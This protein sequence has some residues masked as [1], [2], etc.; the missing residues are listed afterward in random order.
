MQSLRMRGNSGT[1]QALTVALRVRPMNGN[2]INIGA[3]HISHVVDD[4]L[5]VLQDPNDDAD[6]ILRVNRSREKHYTFDCA[7]GPLSTQGDV[8]QSTTKGLIDGVLG[9]YN[10][11]VFAYGPTGA[12]KTYTML[13]TGREPGIMMLTLNDLYSEIE[14]NAEEITCRVSISYLE[15]YNEMIRDLLNPGIG[16]LEL[17]EDHRGVNVVGLKEVETISVEEIMR[18]LSLGNSHR[19]CEPTAINKTSSRSHAVLQV[20]V[21]VRARVMDV[22]QEVKTGKLFMVDLAGSERAAQTKNKGKRMLEGA[23]INR[24][25]LALGNCI[26]ALGGP[27]KVQYVNYRDSKL[28]RLLKDSLGGNCRT[29]MIAHVSPAS[30]SFDESRNTLKYAERAKHI[31]TKI[32]VKVHDVSYHILQYNNIIADLR[33]EIER[34]KRQLS[35]EKAHIGSSSSQ[36]A[37]EFDAMLAELKRV[38]LEQGDRRQELV[39]VECALTLNDLEIQKAKL[40]EEYL[41][42]VGEDETEDIL[43]SLPHDLVGEELTASEEYERRAVLSHPSINNGE[44]EEDIGIAGLRGERRKLSLQQ[45][46]LMH[47]LGHMNARSTDLSERLQEVLSTSLQKEVVDMLLKTNSLEMHFAEQSQVAACIGLH[48]SDCE[49]LI[50][51]LLEQNSACIA[52]IKGQ[53]EF[54][55]KNDIEYPPEFEVAYQKLL[56]QH[57]Y[58]SNWHSW[59]TRL[60]SIP[61][62]AHLT[63]GTDDG[64]DEASLG[65]SPSHQGGPHSERLGLDLSSSQNLTISS[66]ASLPS[67][68]KVE[69]VESTTSDPEN[70]RPLSDNATKPLQDK[71][72]IIKTSPKRLAKSFLP[73]LTSPKLSDEEEDHLSLLP[74]STKTKIKSKTSRATFPKLP[75][76]KSP[77]LISVSRCSTMS[78]NRTAKK[79]KMALLDSSHSLSVVS[80]SSLG[81]EAWETTSK[82]NKTKSSHSQKS[83]LSHTAKKRSKKAPKHVV[84]S[85]VLSS[86]PDLQAELRQTPTVN[87]DAILE[88]R[89]KASQKK[90]QLT[91][92]ST[93]ARD[94][95]GVSIKKSQKTIKRA[96]K[97][98]MAFSSPYATKPPP[99]NTQG[100]ERTRQSLKIS[101]VGFK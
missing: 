62:E 82:K 52:T 47:K 40:K 54:I 5:V 77:P 38:L 9:G 90:R 58:L 96:P 19:T 37:R 65:P 70:S 92:D 39:G 14:A 33:R 31:K 12:G 11:T 8:Y 59:S 85:D 67:I 68:S 99:S 15:I 48:L 27:S 21:E 81:S 16:M 76:I 26:N 45:R 86:Q 28:T 43:P 57:R 46:T 20:V 79:Q 42:V 34:L 18:L 71:Q 78:R 56:R 10:A 49:A 2:E 97:V 73:N 63:D 100:K 50:E 4:K 74:L 89:K 80:D 101:G 55:R 61:S 88:R 41:P 36:S 95:A 94:V 24:S 7:F 22:S 13:G 53:R 93:K 17:R 91:L 84:T 6:D 3:H 35:H 29:V 98:K 23:H 25:L 32:S 75:S 1:Q 87:V 72:R 51:Q 66:V 44:G 69:S 30:T 64:D 60:A 83:T